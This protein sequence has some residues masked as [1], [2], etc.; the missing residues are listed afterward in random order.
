MSFFIYYY[1]IKK[2]AEQYIKYINKNIFNNF[3]IVASCTLFFQKLPNPA[4]VP[5]PESENA[6]M[7]HICK[8]RTGFL[9]MFLFWFLSSRAH[10]L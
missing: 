8:G 10:Q 3:L 6:P 7:L 5:A 9:Y 4:P 1:Y 2:H